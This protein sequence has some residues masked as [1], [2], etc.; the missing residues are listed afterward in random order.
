M[1]FNNLKTY[2]AQRSAESAIAKQEKSTAKA[3]RKQEKLQLILDECAREE[4]R[5]WGPPVEAQKG[6]H[7]YDDEEGEYEV[8]RLTGRAKWATDDAGLLF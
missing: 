6:L 3:T 8:L 4:T 2:L 5:R 7:D 1:V